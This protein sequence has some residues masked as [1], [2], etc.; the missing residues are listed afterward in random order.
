MQALLG[1]TA[2]RR[3][4]PGDGFNFAEGAQPGNGSDRRQ[5]DAGSLVE[6]GP[7]GE[8]PTFGVAV[9]H[10]R[11]AY[12]AGNA[13]RIL[14]GSGSRWDGNQPGSSLDA[15]GARE[16]LPGEARPTRVLQRQPPAYH[17][18]WLFNL[19][20]LTSISALSWG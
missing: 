17:H 18:C 4:E 8:L 19:F 6:K 11:T 9:P 5:L 2:F 20:P 15:A 3:G 10:P 13:W 12:G 16:V 14:E 7:A 1:M